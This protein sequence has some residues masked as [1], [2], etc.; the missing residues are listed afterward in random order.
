MNVRP[1]RVAMAA[2]IAVVAGWFRRVEKVD[3]MEVLQSH[4]TPTKIVS[5]GKQSLA[6]LLAELPHTFSMLSAKTLYAQNSRTVREALIKLGPHI[7]WNGLEFT[8]RWFSKV[9]E[10]S[11]L[12]TIMFVATSERDTKDSEDTVPAQFIYAVMKPHRSADVGRPR[13]KSKYIYECGSAHDM[14]KKKLVWFTFYVS[15]DAGGNIEALPFRQYRTVHCPNAKLKQNR[16]GNMRG[17]TYQQS[18]FALPD[19]ASEGEATGRS[20][21]QFAAE[22]FALVANFWA[23]KEHQWSVSCRKGK[24]RATFCVP[25]HE[26]KTYFKHRDINALTPTGK[27]KTII[28]HV[29]AHERKLASGKITQVKE[30]IRGQRRFYWEGYECAVTAPKFH[31]WTSGRF[32]VQPVF[33]DEHK[34]DTMELREVAEMIAGLEDDQTTKAA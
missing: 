34:G 21:E 22:S 33:D 11:K 18:Y 10:P 8:G 24:R 15:V 32:S 20:P 12:S 2:A 31:T 30:H 1:F 25:V 27:R 14:E 23:T 7:P 13:H 3:P 28:H 16:K 26:T 4:G 29:V 17:R 9:R 19:F 5:Y 6:Q